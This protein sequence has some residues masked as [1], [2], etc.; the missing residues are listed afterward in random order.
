MLVP[1]KEPHTWHLPFRRL[2]LTRVLYFLLTWKYLKNGSN[3]FIKLITKTCNVFYI[4]DLN[5]ATIDSCGK[6]KIEIHIITIIKKKQT[7]LAPKVFLEN[8]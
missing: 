7:Q 5:F 6:P 1:F 2:A 3:F 8:V 4:R